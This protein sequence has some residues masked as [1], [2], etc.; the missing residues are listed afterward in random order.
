[1]VRYIRIFICFLPLVA[2]LFACNPQKRVATEMQQTLHQQIVYAE[3][4][5]DKLI[6]YINH[7]SID[8]LQTLTRNS[9]NALF[10]VFDRR[11]MVFWSDNWLAAQEIRLLNY[12]QWYYQ[13]F[14]NAH[15]VCHW[16]KV[17][18]YNVLTVIPIKTDYSIQNSQLQNKY[19]YPFKPYQYYDISFDNQLNPDNSVYAPNGKYLFSVI[20]QEKKQQTQP[21]RLADSFS[22]QAVLYSGNQSKERSLNVR[23]FFVLYIILFVAVFLLGFYGVIKNRGFG[24]M[25]LGTKFLYI[26]FS[27]LIL[28]S[29]LVFSISTTHVRNNYRQRQHDNLERTTKYI[30]KALQDA[31]SWSLT[32]DEQNTRGMNIDL[33]DL[34]ITYETDIH[35]YDM[36]GMLI[37]TSTPILFD[38]GL[39]SRHISPIPFFEQKESMIL[40]EQ[41]GAMKYVTAYTRFY[42]ANYIQIGYIAVPLFIS[43]YDA[44]ANVNEFLSKMLPVTLIVLFLAFVL[45]FYFSRS[46]TRPL[47]ALSESMKELKVGKRSNH[48]QY[49]AKDE[50]GE[51]VR[52]YNEMVDQLEHSLEMLARSERE[53]AWRTM[54]RQIAHEINNTL[55]PMKLTL[56]QLQR[57]KNIGGEKFD[58]YFQKSTKL[59]IEQIDS[60]SS[61]AVSFSQFAKMPEVITSEV[62]VAQKLYS[63]VELMRNDKQQ[64]PIRYVG[65]QSGVTAIADAEQIARVFT[66]LI[67]NAQ[68]ALEEKGEGDIIVILKEVP[69]VVEI[70]VSDN[71][72]GIPKEIRDKIFRPNF[73]TKS[74]GMGLG[75]AISKNIVEGCGGKIDFTTSDKGTTFIVRLNKE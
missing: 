30:Q 34:S 63:V 28:V 68:Q 45:N 72:S 6:E 42:N 44:D 21:T 14:D 59:L 26:S 5:T 52:R 70:S 55:T 47:T 22:Y 8:S 56:Q 48:L 17:G 23:V 36:Q 32:L 62:D 66:N 43:E 50:V 60:L 35:V 19:I 53:T 16:R 18:Q 3:K 51:L 33:R 61:I 71:G 24:D 7:E 11:G 15:C 57:A 20:P 75:L 54:A 29:V 39:I 69:S 40:D 37:G 1:M 58:D 4:Q 38:K 27:L 31:Y 73:T 64:I 65:A 67:K 74:T 9:G 25:K 46:L 2:F 13:H 12:D 10:Y 49:G 41:I